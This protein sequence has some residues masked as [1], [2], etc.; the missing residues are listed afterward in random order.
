MVRLNGTKMSKSLGNLVMID[1]LL[2]SWSPDTL[3]V[4][5]AS[6]HHRE[7]WNHDPSDMARAQ[8]LVEELCAAVS[9]PSGDGPSLDSSR[10]ETRFLQAMEEDLNTPLAL[11]AAGDMARHVHGAAE[12]GCDVRTAQSS[13]RATSEIIG[14][15]LGAEPEDRVITGWERHRRKLSENP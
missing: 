4:Y 5:L 12:Q 8:E 1:D 11:K 7:S 10:L 15:R 2:T 3:R 6:H 9:I 13:L 14:L